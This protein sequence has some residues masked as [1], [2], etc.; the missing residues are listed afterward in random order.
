MITHLNS[1]IPLDIDG[2]NQTDALTDGILILRHMFGVSDNVLITGAI[3]ENASYTQASEIELRINN[4]NELLDI[5]QSGSIDA[6]TDGLLILRYL[7]GLTGEGMVANVVSTS[8]QRSSSEEIQ[9]YLKILTA[10]PP[11][12]ESDSVFFVNENQLEIG[13]I[14]AI[15]PNDNKLTYSISGDDMLISSLGALYFREVPD[16]EV[17]AMYLSTVTVTNGVTA[18]SQNITVNILDLDDTAPLFTSSSVFSIEEN[19]TL[20]GTITT[21]DV[22]SD[23]AS[24]T[25]S[26]SGTDLQIN[27]EGSLNFKS[28]PDYELQTSYDATIT[29]TDGINS[30]DQNITVSILDLDDT[31]PLFTSSSV[32]SIEENKTLVGTITTQDV[33]SDEASITYSVSGTDLQINSEGSL[34]FK[35]P[36]NYERK[37]LYNATITATDGINSSDQNIT[38]NILDLDDTVMADYFLFDKSSPVELLDFTMPPRGDGTHPGNLSEGYRTGDFNGD[39]FEDSA[40]VISKDCVESVLLVNYGSTGGPSAIE[41]IVK[42]FYGG[43]R[44]SV[45]DLNNDGYDDLSIIT[46]ANCGDSDTAGSGYFRFLIGS[47]EGLEDFTD[48]IRN[49]TRNDFDDTR[50]DTFGFTDIDNDGL[51]ELLVLQNGNPKLKEIPFWIEYENSEFI[52][53]WV[54]PIKEEDFSTNCMHEDSSL[55]NYCIR[56]WTI[57]FVSAFLDIDHDGDIDYVDYAYPKDKNRDEFIARKIEGTSEGIDFS[58]YPEEYDIGSTIDSPYSHWWLH[59]NRDLNEDGYDDLITWDTDNN[60]NDNAIQKISTYM[61]SPNGLL[62]SDEWSPSYFGQSSSSGQN[63]MDENIHFFDVDGDGID[64]WLVPMLGFRPKNIA[65][66]TGVK[67]N[68][69]TVMKKSN[70]NWEFTEITSDDN[71]LPYQNPE[72]YEY[73]DETG[74]IQYVSIYRTLWGDYDGDGDLDTIFILTYPTFEDQDNKIIVRYYENIQIAR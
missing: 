40:I 41:T 13:N 20:V 50:G 36:P 16:Y 11:L 71:G 53:R 66:E 9:D 38:V 43:R 73:E 3:S 2:D 25:Y 24:I 6:L 67:S 37:R 47:S 69:L 74:S 1:K 56:G 21:Q 4:L 8:A 58:I 55:R 22:D 23:E 7:F 54:D 68:N 62:L 18:E 30:S 5:D 61:S 34:N 51:D 31:A 72:F 44:L 14:S 49:S 70:T 10:P 33:D 15:D 27:S 59:Y 35:S 29:A 48:E 19:K 63:R 64:E 17:K 28:P 46:Q 52:A 26:V 57:T 32:F 39:G 12:I 60:H 65:E 42:P 45:N